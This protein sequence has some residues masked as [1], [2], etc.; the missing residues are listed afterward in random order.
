MEPYY[1]GY[2]K[3][4]YHA[5]IYHDNSN[6]TWPSWWAEVF[7]TY[8]NSFLSESDAFKFLTEEF[9]DHK[10]AVQRVCWVAEPVSWRE[11]GSNI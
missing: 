9:P 8:A 3:T 6:S 5:F 1:D 7:P 2:P 4:R 10:H 11:K